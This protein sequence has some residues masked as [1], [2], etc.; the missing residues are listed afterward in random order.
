MSAHTV[1]DARG[2]VIGYEGMVT[3]LTM[4]KWVEGSVQD[5]EKRFITLL[6]LIHA[7]TFL[8]QRTKFLGGKPNCGGALQVFCD[9]RGS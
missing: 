2:R 5:A 3:D 1:L 7:A 4:Q 9:G 8:Y 6:E